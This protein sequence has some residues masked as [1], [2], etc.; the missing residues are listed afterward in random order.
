M[1]HKFSSSA[2]FGLQAVTLMA[3]SLVLPGGLP[4]GQESE[5]QP[6]P[7]EQPIR[8]R[9]EEVVVDVIVTDRNGKPV[10][11]L[12]PADFEI[13]EDGVRQQI[14][15]FRLESRAR[16]ESTESAKDKPLPE[17]ARGNTVPTAHLVSL[18]FDT[19]GTGRDGA[20]MARRAVEDYVKNLM[21]DDAFVAVFGTGISMHIFQP[22]TKD[23]AALLK[24]IE[25]VTSGDLQRFG[26]ISSE[27]RTQ[28]ESIVTGWSDAE[29]MTAAYGDSAS[30]IVGSARDEGMRSDPNVGR[31]ISTLALASLRTLLVFQR[32]EREY[33]G[34]MNVSGLLAIID[35][36]RIFAGRKTILYFSGGFMV[37]PDVAPQFRSVISAANRANVTIYAVDTAGLRLDNPSQPSTLEVDAILGGRGR[38]PNPE[39]VVGGRSALGRVEEVARMNTLTNLDELSSETGGYTIKNTNDLKS[40]LHRIIEDLREYY[41]LTYTPENSNFDGKFRRI[42][43]NVTRPELSVRSRS[44]YY[45]F[46]SRDS[47][48]IV[49]FEA[50]LLET[51]N[52]TSPGDE[53]PLSMGAYHFLSKNE[54]RT[55]ALFLE[56]PMSAI[57]VEVDKK[58]K[59]YQAHVDAMI[60]L[61]EPGG[62]VLRKLSREYSLDGSLEQLDQAQK[63]NLSF[64]R[65]VPIAPGRYALE[66]V[67]RDRLTGKAAVKRETL[68]VAPASP[69]KIQI[70]SLILS[71]N[72]IPASEAEKMDKENPFVVQASANVMPDLARVYRKSTDKH[73]LVYFIVYPALQSQ[74]PVEA[75]LQFQQNGK[76][77]ARAGGS[78]PGPDSSGRIQYVTTFDL[79]NFEPGDY[80][81]QV[82]VK[83][84][85]SSASTLGTFR[86]QP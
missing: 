58:R 59:T 4:F 74:S 49:G 39:L 57:K 36:Q 72:A 82:T 60:L 85:R 61:K 76:L 86:V 16:V 17:V 11:N 69:E 47:M 19:T 40:G 79:D 66:A 26:S 80:S 9:S 12:T 84:G 83:D 22:F 18:V 29:K 28:L 13:Y 56:F 2:K 45:A 62:A 14:K 24:A 27:I 35:A 32:Y 75:T 53:F 34:R 73:L 10:S 33:Q 21:A 54:A 37:S 43:V 1:T 63:R 31:D 23:R 5:R 15:S 30:Y 6:K 50:Q 52:A 51:L 70:S 3:L 71:K 38:N 25:V 55:A 78:L 81:L 77:L 20:L 44:G 68:V 48:P 8:V 64:L 7:G 46:R 42:V 65:T 41:V 67:V